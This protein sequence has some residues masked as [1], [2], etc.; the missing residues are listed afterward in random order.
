[1]HITFKALGRLH[2]K[3]SAFTAALSALCL[4]VI[5][6]LY[7]FEIVMRYFLHAPTSWSSAI[8]VYL[9]LAMVTLMLPYISKMTEHI[10]VNIIEEYFSPRCA[11]LNAVFINVLAVL[12]C[13]LSAYFVISETSRAF[14]RGTLTT[15]TLF[16]P[17]W[18][19]LALFVYGLSSATVHFARLLAAQIKRGDRPPTHS[20]TEV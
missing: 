16:I 13:F 19:L 2:D 9:M 17:K 1:M 10:T 6:T 5:V 20:A 12:I 3:L 15:D 11:F 14:S 18:W 4:G 7:C 8:A